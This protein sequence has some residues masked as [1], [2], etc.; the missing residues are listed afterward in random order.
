MTHEERAEQLACKWGLCVETQNAILTAIKEAVKEATKP[1]KESC[2]LWM[3][4]G[5]RRGLLSLRDVLEH[6]FLQ[7]FEQS[8]LIDAINK[9]LDGDD[10]ELGAIRFHYDSIL[11]ESLDEHQS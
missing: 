10:R 11:R 8:K 6:R 4:E 3:P 7:S 9:A 2:K 5:Y 1:L